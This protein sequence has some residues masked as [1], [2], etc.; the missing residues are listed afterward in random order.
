MRYRRGKIKREHHSLPE[1]EP[2]L[3]ALAAHPAVSAVIPGPISRKKSSGGPRVA[4]A[5]GGGGSLHFTVH[6]PLYVQSV[7]AVL[8]PA[9][10]AQVLADLRAAGILAPDAPPASRP[11]LK[12]RP[13][14]PP[15]PAPAPPGPQ[16]VAVLPRMA[17]AAVDG[18]APG[19]GSDVLARVRAALPA[20]G[21]ARGRFVYLPLG[22]LMVAVEGSR[23]AAAFPYRRPW[24]SAQAQEDLAEE[25]LGPDDAEAMILAAG[26]WGRT[27]DFATQGWELVLD[28]GDLVGARLMRPADG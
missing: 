28:R 18:A 6:S 17:V 15:R 22:D 2:L 13:A 23:L 7:H 3:A 20:L 5:P 24:V 25:G 27:G 9:A 16:R 8:P 19:V 14:P 1:A 10:R 21:Y 26:L 4:V 12:T 11:R